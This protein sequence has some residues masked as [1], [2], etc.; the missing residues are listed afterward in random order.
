MHYHFYAFR[1]NIRFRKL[2]NFSTRV[3]K[4]ND[5][6]VMGRDKHIDFYEERGENSMKIFEK[7]QPAKLLPIAIFG[8]G[9]LTSVLT[10]KNSA[11]ER[12][13][14]KSE[15]KEELLKELTSTEN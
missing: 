13:V 9:I 6:L 8:L 2:L 3:T 14:M 15:L 12:E 1:T 7:M 4:L 10:N 11:I 5:I